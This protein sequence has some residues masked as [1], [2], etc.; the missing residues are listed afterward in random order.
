MLPVCRHS[1]HRR[2]PG[3]RLL[4]AVQIAER[5]RHGPVAGNR[6][7]VHLDGTRRVRAH[8]RA[9]K[10]GARDHERSKRDGAAHRAPL[11]PPA[12][13]AVAAARVMVVRG[14]VA[15]ERDDVVEVVV[16]VVVLEFL[17]AGSRESVL[18]APNLF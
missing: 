12:R 2:R 8:G 7:A 16:V 18:E 3:D 13:V 17:G 14:S 1:S 4:R 10:D 15:V 5:V 11:F 9:Q 6:G